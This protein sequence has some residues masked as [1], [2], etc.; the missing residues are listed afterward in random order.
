MNTRKKI[1]DK[2]IGQTEGHVPWICLVAYPRAISQQCTPATH[3]EVDAI[4]ALPSLVLLGVS[5]PIS[6][7]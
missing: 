1:Q 4:S 2:S 3:A 6:D 7:H 5:I